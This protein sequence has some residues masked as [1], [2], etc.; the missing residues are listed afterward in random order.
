MKNYLEKYSNADKL[1]FHMPGH[2]GKKIFNHNV[3]LN[4]IDITEIDGADNLHNPKGIIKESMN[5]ATK[6]FGTK[7][8]YYLLNGSTS[9]IQIAIT[10]T[11][12]PG[13][14]ILAQRDSHIS[15]YN[16]AIIVGGHLKYLKSFY[17][18]KVG[19]NTGIDTEE[20]EKELESDS[21]IKVV[22]ITYPT[23]YGVCSDLKKISEVV[24]KYNRILIVDEAHGS[25]FKFHEKLPTSAID[26]GADLVIQSTH[27]TLTGLTQTA[28]LHICTDKVDRKRVR[29]SFNLLHT[30]SPSYI[31]MYSL[32]W[33]VRNILDKKKK[34][35]D[36]LISS[37]EKFSNEV[38]GLNTINIIN[39]K[40]FL[41]DGIDFDI[42]KLIL[43]KRNCSGNKLKEYLKA[44][45]IEIEMTDFKY[46]VLLLSLEDTKEDF[47][48]LFQSLKRIDKIEEKE[49]QE[50]KNLDYTIPQKKMEIREAFFSKIE[51][52]NIKKATDKVSGGFVIP[53]PPGIPIL[54]P[55]ES[56]SKN[57]IE[58]IE[59]FTENRADIIGMEDGR[60]KVLKGK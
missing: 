1:R 40:S 12:S 41:N 54:V 37:I 4:N 19:I 45:N 34:P 2:K 24:K 57:I 35:F 52:V 46:C 5:I 48:R 7:E 50:K 25:H 21:D 42:T 39:K 58:I 38:S 49:S 20:L 6:I 56:I 16:S 13:E 28:M 26:L 14:K 17:D 51:E 33:T 9:G 10:A 3:N 22:F 53:Y 29:K 43:E 55:G 15:L 30:T 36:K 27:K 8:T 44:E 47:K 23:Y 60:I 11:L 18:K 31:L 59:K 32:D